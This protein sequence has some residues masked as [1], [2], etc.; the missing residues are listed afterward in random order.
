M[1]TSP[2]V[3]EPFQIEAIVSPRRQSEG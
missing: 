2:N 3:I 1:L